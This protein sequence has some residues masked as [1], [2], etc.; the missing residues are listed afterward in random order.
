[1]AAT[2]TLDLNWAGLPGSIATALLHT[3]DGSILIDPGPS[4]T[5]PRLR[6]QLEGHGLRTQ[7]L[8]A[9]LLTHIHMDHAG[10]TGSLVKEHPRLQ[11]YVHARG[12]PHLVD[13][14]NLLKSAKMLFGEDME[15]LFGEFQPVASANLKILEGGEVLSLGSRRIQVLYTP[16]HANHHVTYFDHAEG[17]AFVGDTTG[18]C[19]EGHAFILPAT[20]PPDVNLELW[21]ASLDAIGGLHPQELFLTHFGYA[22]DS[23]RHIASYRQRLHHWSELTARLLSTIADE[24]EARHAFAREVASEAAQVLSPEEVSKLIFIG[25][26]QLSWLGLARYHRKRAAAPR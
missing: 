9:V 23:Q 26:L 25:S 13:P 4:S 8:R 15:S 3:E 22:Q 11:V 18:I 6:E 2:H 17:T 24:T 7:D 20:P 12:A 19:I 1:V 10:A 14:S 21:D 16:G 5:L